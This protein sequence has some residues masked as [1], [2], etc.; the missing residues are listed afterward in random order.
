MNDK[1]S[2]GALEQ[3]DLPQPKLN[4]IETRV[5]TS[6]VTSSLHVDDIVKF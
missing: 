1:K 5:D 6:A 3:Y 2:V 4:R